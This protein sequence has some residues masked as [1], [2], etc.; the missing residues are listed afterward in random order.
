M[1]FLELAPLPTA[2]PCARLHARQVLWEWGLQGLGNVTELII[3]ELVTNAAQAS[4]GLTGSRYE[5]RWAPGA[6]PVRLWIQS[7]KHDV[8]VQVWDGNDRM[9]Q[10]REPGLDEES[11]RGLLLIET[12]SQDYGAYSLEGC[13][14]K[15]V[16]GVIGGAACLPAP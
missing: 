10:R 5:C 15:V 6:P 14:G 12:L 4:E 16:W 7:D 1:S 11:G 13:S 9:P 2:V 3:S 8:L